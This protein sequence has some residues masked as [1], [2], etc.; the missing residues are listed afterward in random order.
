MTRKALRGGS[1]SFDEKGAFAANVCAALREINRQHNEVTSKIVTVTQERDAWIKE[2]QEE[3]RNTDHQKDLGFKHTKAILELKK[4]RDQQ[5]VLG[6]AYGKIIAK[7]DANEIDP[8]MSVKAI[9]DD[10]TSE[11]DGDDDS[12]E[13]RSPQM[14]LVGT[15]NVKATSGWR[16]QYK[17]C[18]EAFGGR[19]WPLVHDQ[20][21]KLMSVSKEIWG[22]AAILNPLE[23]ALGI[24]TAFQKCGNTENRK[25]IFPS[26]QPW[27]IAGVADLMSRHAG[28][29]LGIKGDVEAEMQAGRIA[30]A[31]RDAA[32]HD[33]DAFVHL[34]GK[35][36]GV[37]R[38][39]A[40]N[41][42]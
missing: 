9:I 1:S 33:P 14:R 19:E 25:G 8:T 42:G 41:A 15:H 22:R 32:D 13:D 2:F 5:R 39:V 29:E 10:T 6:H 17:A 21:S 3:K 34:F 27:A 40:A 4:L 20:I 11:D 28:M 26:M 30:A 18:P 16:D 24:V 23:L 35:D 36:S 38:L 31:L 12:E 7:A 37:N